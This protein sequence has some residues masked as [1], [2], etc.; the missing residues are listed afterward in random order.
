MKTT[1]AIACRI[2]ADYGYYSG[3]FHAPSD[4]YLMGEPNYDHFTGRESCSPLDFDTV[5]AAYKYL[6]GGG[7]DCHPSEGRSCEYDGGDAKFSRGGTYVTAHGQHSRPRYTIVS[8]KSGRCTK[9][10]IAECERI[11][12]LIAA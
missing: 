7:C 11:S 4:G 8:R 9:A 1:T 10:I 3:T 2:K 6:T 5:E 12:S